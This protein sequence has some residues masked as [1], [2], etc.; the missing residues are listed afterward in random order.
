[1]KIII[2]KSFE[3]KYILKFKKYFSIEELIDTL[4]EE[5]NKIILNYPYYKF[6][7]QINNVAFRWI[8]MI[9]EDSIIPFVLYLKKDK[10]YWENIIWKNFQKKILDMQE[11]VSIDLKNGDIEI[12]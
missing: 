4:R 3:K 6:K 5:R 7:F 8:V 12:F 1:M 9:V 10:K 11:R 2:T